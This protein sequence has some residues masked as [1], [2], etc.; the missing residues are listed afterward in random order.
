MV[1]IRMRAE[2]QRL[3][4]KHIPSISG[5]TWPALQTVKEVLMSPFGNER[6]TKF[7]GKFLCALIFLK[8]ILVILA[9]FKK[10]L[11]CGTNRERKHG[12]SLWYYEV[13]NFQ[14]I[15]MNVIPFFNSIW[16]FICQKEKRLLEVSADRQDHRKK[17]HLTSKES[18]EILRI[19]KEM[20][21]GG[22][23]KY[24]DS[25]ILRILRDYMP[26]TVR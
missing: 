15:Q 13:N 21:D 22:K 25:E 17:D 24:S 20:N 16:L 19:R 1:I 11:R 8:K 3:N 23:R 12:W 9:L 18:R 2:N 14:S 26:N 4:P 7:L 5:T 10:H 6:I